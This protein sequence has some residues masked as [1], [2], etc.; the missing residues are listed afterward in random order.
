MS[1]SSE[2]G[3]DTIMRVAEVLK[4]DAKRELAARLL[5]SANEAEGHPEGA[6]NEDAAKMPSGVQGGE[7]LND[8]LGIRRS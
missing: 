2:S 4:P 3:V 6:P 1:E 8:E 5:R 7:W